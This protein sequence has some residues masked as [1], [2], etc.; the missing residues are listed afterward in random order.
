MKRFVSGLRTEIL[1]SLTVLLVAA[2]VL[3]SFV[4]SRIWER[5]LLRYKAADGKVLIQRIQAAVDEISADGAAP[6]DVVKTKLEYFA[7]ENVPEGLF[8]PLVVQAEDGTFWAGNHPDR[9]S[10]TTRN[11]VFSAALRLEKGAFHVSRQE[12]LLVVS[13]P[14]FWKHHPVA[15]MQVP[16]RIDSVLQGLRQSQRLIWFYIGLNVLVLLVFG[17]FL[18]SRVIIRPIN[19]LVRTA[20]DFENTKGPYSFRTGSEHNEMGR[21][22]MSLNSMLKRLAENKEQMETQIQCLKEANIELKEARDEVL[23]SEKLSSL[24]R[25]AAGIAH[26]VGNP[27]GSILGYTGLLSAQVKHDSEAGDYLKRIESEISRISTIIRELLDYARSS[28][29]NPSP[30]DINALV[31]ETVGFFSHQKLTRGVDLKTHLAEDVGVVWADADQVKQVLINLL[32]NACDALDGPGQ[33]TIDTRR[34]PWPHA[35]T[36]NRRQGECVEI[37]VSDTGAGIPVSEHEKIFDPFFTTKPPGKGTG[38]GLAVSRRIV[39]S[40]GGNLEVKS[41]EGKGSAFTI[42]LNPWEPNHDAQRSRHRPEC[43]PA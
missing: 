8:D 27:L 23:R 14:L 33:I 7:A 39:E 43:Y 19:R 20:E 1:L 11:P 9:Q 28:P 25:L 4:V 40:F 13:A 24:G 36:T 37:T 2:M 30:V 6:L 15:V 31:S 38:L 32:F 35:T 29:S 26:E 42:R 16:V 34:Q 41:H 21:L 17:T 22:A 12:D 3:T 5:D 10:L 18:L